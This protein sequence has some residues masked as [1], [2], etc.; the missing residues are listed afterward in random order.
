VIAAL[1]LP[2]GLAIPF[3]GYFLLSVANLSVSA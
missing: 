3:N 2:D 1:A